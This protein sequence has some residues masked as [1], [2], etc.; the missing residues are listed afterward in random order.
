MFSLFFALASCG[1]SCMEHLGGEGV[2]KL[3]GQA[4]SLP[5]NTFSFRIAVFVAL[6]LLHL[7]FNLDCNVSFFFFFFFPVSISSERKKRGRYCMIENIQAK[8]IVSK[9]K[10]IL[11]RCYNPQWDESNGAMA[12][13]KRLAVREAACN[14]DLRCHSL[15][16]PAQGYLM[17]EGARLVV[18]RT[19]PR[20]RCHNCIQLHSCITLVASRR[21][22]HVLRSAG[23]LLALRALTHSA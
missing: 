7:S 14:L 18:H 16:Q 15:S 19:I 8:N 17:A 3:A 2:A 13:S 10:D 11:A 12:L 1:A 20:W 23:E 9:S 4:S 5:A 6:C 21:P 22:R